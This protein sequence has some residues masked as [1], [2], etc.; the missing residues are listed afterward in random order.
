[1]FTDNQ[2]LNEETSSSSSMAMQPA[3]Q[4][5]V[6]SVS[7]NGNEIN[8]YLLKSAFSRPR[9]TGGLLTFSSEKRRRKNIF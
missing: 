7:A 9:F 3:G 8:Y 5:T 2:L 4:A 1:V 6:F